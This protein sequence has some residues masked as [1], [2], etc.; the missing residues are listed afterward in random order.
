MNNK[1]REY[2]FNYYAKNCT[3]EMCPKEIDLLLI[4]VRQRKAMKG[5]T[6]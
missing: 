3:F 4:M 1:C 6:V 2:G 5:H